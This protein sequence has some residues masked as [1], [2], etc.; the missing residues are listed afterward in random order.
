MTMNELI[1]LLIF[2]WYDYEWINLSTDICMVFFFQLLRDEGN[3][4][5]KRKEVMD[6]KLLDLQ[7][8]KFIPGIGTVWR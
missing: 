5:K 2:V 4:S 8:K 1:S 6:A 3:E 7:N